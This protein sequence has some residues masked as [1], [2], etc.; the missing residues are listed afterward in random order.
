MRRG[1][2]RQ[3]VNGKDHSRLIAVLKGNTGG[4]DI[5][6]KAAGQSGLRIACTSQR[7][8]DSGCEMLSGIADLQAILGSILSGAAATGAQAQKH[9]KDKQNGHQFFHGITSSYFLWSIINIV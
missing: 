6:Y 7:C 9:S 2:D 4:V 5:V 1:P 3:Q 8:G